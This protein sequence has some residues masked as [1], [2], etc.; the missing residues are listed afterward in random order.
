MLHKLRAGM[1]RPERDAVGSL[2]LVEVGETL[3]GGR[4]RGEGRGIHHKATVVAAI[5]VRTRMPTQNNK[6]HKRVVYAGRLRLRLVPGRGTKELKGFV[7][8]NVAQGAVVRTDGCRGYDDLAKLGYTHEPLVLDGDPERTDAHLPMIHIAF[9]NLKTW[10]LGTHHG[11]SQQHLQ[12]Y[13]NEFVFR[14]NR[15]FYPMT[16]FNSPLGLAAH[17]CALTY[18]TLYSGEWTHPTA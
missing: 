8:E 11:V 5:E 4:T 14:F 18:E 13:L 12:A 17:A 6:K 16:T 9:S 3:V 15:R 1:V 10:L 7:Q 2:H